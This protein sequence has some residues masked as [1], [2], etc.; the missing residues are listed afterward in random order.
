MI[1][2]QFLEPAS[3]TL[4]YIIAKKVD[5][6]A[7]IID[8]VITEVER[9]VDFLTANNLTLTKA[10]DTHIHADHITALPWLRKNLKCITMMGEESRVTAVSI[11][12][13]DGDEIEVDEDISLKVIKTPGHTDDSYCFYTEG[14]VFTGDTLFI[15]GNGRTDFQN[16]SAEALYD[17]ITKK[18]WTLPDPTTVYPGHDYKGELLSTIGR[19][20]K[21]NPR[22]A[23]KSREEFI[24]IMDNLNLPNPKLMDIAVPANMRTG[25]DLKIGLKDW[26]KVYSY[27]PQKYELVVDLRSKEE[28]AL[29][30]GLDG[31]VN[32]NYPDV[33]ATLKDESSEFNQALKG[34]DPKRILLFCA[35]GE[36]SH[37]VLTELKNLGIEV[38]HLADGLNGIEA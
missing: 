14:M 36:R 23:G 12:F 38:A 2:K 29:S 19:E 25:E 6:K 34:K 26:Q 35:H 3:K 24:E 21:E 8:P 33:I 31:S 22:F 13:K 5:G 28:I 10:L 15:R 1:V 32:F 37:V 17:S 18:L 27:D 11:R 4:T 30:P 20:K 7:V 9:Y 16:G